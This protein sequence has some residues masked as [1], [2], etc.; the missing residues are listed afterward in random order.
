MRGTSKSEGEGVSQSM[1]KSARAVSA[2][3]PS[4]GLRPSLDLS[5]SG[6]VNG[7]LGGVIGASHATQLSPLP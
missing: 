7:V 6:E 2:P 3:S 1:R 4:L 5:P